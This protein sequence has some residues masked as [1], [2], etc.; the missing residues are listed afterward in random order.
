M[1]N[2]NPYLHIDRQIVGDIYTSNEAMEN[3]T[4]LCDD[5]GSRFAGTP[6]EYAAANFILETFNRY[7]LKNVRLEAY[8]Y[9]GWSRGEATLQITAPLQRTLPCISLPYCPAG[10]VVG[11]WYPSVT[12]VLR[13]ILL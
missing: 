8:P 5:F 12:G 1:E 2:K 7:G 11:D 6:E 9:A 3:L 10:E 13:N 4:V